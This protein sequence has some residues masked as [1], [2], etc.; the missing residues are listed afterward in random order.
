MFKDLQID[1]IAVQNSDGLCSCQ[2]QDGSNTKEVLH[3]VGSETGFELTNQYSFNV[4]TTLSYDNQTI[5]GATEKGI[6]YQT[7]DGIWS[8][9]QDLY[10]VDHSGS[11]HLIIDTTNGWNRYAVYEADLDGN[12][13]S[14]HYIASL[15][16]DSNVDAYVS[17][18]QISNEWI[19][20]QPPLIETNDFTSANPQAIQF[21]DSW[22]NVS[23]RITSGQILN[24]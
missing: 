17:V 21:E 16:A 4:S 2:A 10:F 3:Y 24:T 22:G 19:G 7:G 23:S 8:N 9:N 1:V 6:F 15:I 5:V 11:Q 14:G 12:G 20:T 13:V 18:W